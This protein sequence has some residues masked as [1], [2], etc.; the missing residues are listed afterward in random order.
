M[1]HKKNVNRKRVPMNGSLFRD[2]LYRILFLYRYTALWLF[3][4]AVYGNDSSL[5]KKNWLQNKNYERSKAQEIAMESTEILL[6]LKPE[7]DI[8]AFLRSRG[9]ELKKRLLSDPNMVVL[10]TPS[11]AK[12]REHMAN[13]MSD[14]TVK[15]VYYDVPS[16]NQRMDFTPND[17]FFN[18]GSPQGFPGQW[19]LI[20]NA[21]P[22]F[23]SNVRGAWQ[24]DVTGTGVTIGI[25]D[26]GIDTLHPDLTPNYVAA[27]S[28]DFVGNDP[29]PNPV[30]S[31]ANH[32]T[33]VAG[34]A[35]ARGGNGLGVTGAAPHAKIAGLRLPFGVPGG[36]ISDFVDAVKYHSFG[37]I[38]TIK[39]KNHSYGISVPFVNN[40][41]ER[42]AL[43]ESAAAGTIH[44]YAAGNER[45]EAGEDANKKATQNS[46]NVITVAALANTGRFATYSNFG[47]NVFVTAPSSSFR[48]GEFGVTTTDR[49]G[50]DGY[51]PGG[52]NN[53]YPDRDYTHDF[54]GT[55]SASPLVAGVMALGVQAN[56]NMNVRMAKHLLVRS[57]DVVDENDSTLRSDDGWKTNGAGFRFN[58]NY[59]F[60]L[61]DADEFTQLATQ[62]SGVTPLEAE[63]T[64]VLSVHGNIPDV[65]QITRTFT[66]NSTSPLEELEVRLDIGHSFRGDL[67]AFLT[68]PQGTR[69]RLF[70]RHGDDSGSTGIGWWFT[71]NA[72]WGENPAG[73]WSLTVEDAFE[74][75]VGTW[76]T[77]Q[78]RARMGDLV[79]VN[80]VS[81]PT[82]T[83]FNPPTGP[84]GTTVTVTGTKLSDASAVKFSSIDATEFTVNSPTQL[85]AIVPF[86]ATTG[87]I[88]VITPGGT[89]TT[90][91]NFDVTI[92]PVIREFS[93]IG[94]P[95]GTNITVFG[96]NFV[97]IS[98]VKFNNVDAVFSVNSPTQITAT[99]PENATT[100][101]ITIIGTGG[102]ATSNATFVISLDPVI[103][104][105]SPVSGVPG[106]RVVILGTNFTGVTAVTFNGVNAEFAVDSADQITTTA[107]NGAGTG[108]LSLRTDTTTVDSQGIFSIIAPPVIENFTP[109]I[110]PVASS[111]VII[112]RNFNDVSAVTFNNVASQDV[113]LNSFSQVTATVPA[114]AATGP[115]GVTT[116]AG[117][118]MSENAFV[119][120]A[121]SS[122]DNFANARILAGES[123]AVTDTNIAT[124][125]ETDEQNHA[126][127][128]GGKSIWYQWNAPISGIWNFNTL[129]SNFDTLLAIY[130]GASI[131]DLVLVVAND[132][133]TGGIDDVQ[134]RVTFEASQG[135]LY[136]IAIDGK[137]FDTNVPPN[138][139][140]AS[141]GNVALS[142]ERITAPPTISGFT[143]TSAAVGNNVDIS[144]AGFLGTTTVQF[145]TVDSNAVS[146]VSDNKIIASVPVNATSGPIQVI[147]PL[148]AATS[149]DTLQ[150][151]EASQNDKFSDAQTL[152][153]ASGTVS[154]SNIGASKEP[155]EPNHAGN[156]GGSSIWFR[157]TA[158][159]SGSWSFDTQNSSF[160]TL[161]AV[162]TG[163]AI[164]NL[165]LVAENDDADGL[166]NRASRSIFEVM[167]DTAYSIAVDGYV[168]L[169]GDVILNWSLTPE[170]PSINGFTPT[171]GPVGTV[172][173]INGANLGNIISVSFN[174]KVT[175]DLTIVS[176]SE[177]TVQVP[178]SATSGPIRISSP[179]A[180]VTSEH[181]F[182]V[183]DNSFNDNFVDAELLNGVAAF[184]IGNNSAASKEIGEPNHAGNI[185]GKSIWYSWT[186]PS[187]GSWAFD[188][189]GSGFDTI[190]AVYI[191]DHVGDLTLI[192]SND[193][194][195]SDFTDLTSQVILS[196]SPGITYH[197]AVDG[198]NG[199]SG[200]VVLR[201]FQPKISNSIFF[202]SFETDEGYDVFLPDGSTRQPL[203][204]QNAWLQ[205]GSRGN[206]LSS[207]RFLGF[208]QEAFVGGVVAELVPEPPVD[209]V[210]VWAPIDFTPN[211]ATNPV[212]TFSVVLEVA[213]S[214][215]F[216]YDIFGWEFY[217]QDADFLLGL[218]FNNQTLDISFSLD[219]ESV[220]QTGQSFANGVL[221]FLAIKMD[222]AQNRWSATLDDFFGTKTLVEDA[223]IS[224]TGDNALN[225]G[226]IDAFWVPLN[227]RN[228]GNNAMFFD[229]YSLIEE[230]DN[231]PEFQLQPESQIAIAGET[232][233]FGV[234]AIGGESLRYQWKKDGVNI[235]DATA[236]FLTI[237][238]V[239]EDNSGDYTVEVTSGDDAITSSTATL[240]VITLPIITAQPASQEVK[241]RD[242]AN[243]MVTALSV[244][245]LSYQWRKN[246]EF[247]TNETTDTLSIENVQFED[248][249]SYSAVLSNLAGSIASNTVVLTVIGLTRPLALTATPGD[250]QVSLSW[251]A[252]P[253][254][255]NPITDYIVEFK[256]TADSTFAE[257]NDGVSTST[258][259]SL[260]GLT[261]G[262]SYD[263]R[264][265]AVNSIGIGEAA[266]ITKI[267]GESETRN[268]KL[269]AGWNLISFILEP[270][271]P[272][273]ESTVFGNKRRGQIWYWDGSSYQVATQLISKTGYWV[274]ME[275][276]DEPAITG[277]LDLETEKMLNRS[278]WHLVGPISDRS[279]SNLTDVDYPNWY[280]ENG[281]FKVATEL[282]KWKGYWIF[283]ATPD[284]INLG[285]GSGA[286]NVDVSA[287]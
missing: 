199:D 80:T 254:D 212:L 146:V 88:S 186:A 12:A 173:T 123:G 13:L 70:I 48:Q 138:F 142:W 14:G 257:L 177:L 251:G 182:I 4:L 83:N 282:K 201:L 269:E 248:G 25:A 116:P 139:D 91:T 277:V 247:L 252:P 206:G 103:S 61:I 222:F 113:T 228:P 232:V 176:P 101:R 104:S 71:S 46:P 275:E 86:G 280:W 172:V 60:G 96:D 68:S 7:T 220:T 202:T 125:K 184:T 110:G 181:H 124:T 22:N 265:S 227:S 195:S 31:D 234:V 274:Y 152:L 272:P 17:P 281:Q 92:S 132:D 198:F 93:P 150:I 2:S 58:Q 205:T 74:R 221:Y 109:G 111:V 268:L 167:K 210:L 108:I 258:T 133:I 140:N 121:S 158:P 27:D 107:P 143:P 276:S 207:G 238:N 115:I 67:Q 98:A 45:T 162:Y 130:T 154:G 82:I 261:N 33:S 160:D 185:G 131:N 54:G 52:N 134:S 84:I 226:D 283:L 256:R 159:Q 193:D 99:V 19:H 287:P 32:G 106:T 242:T 245:D 241:V 224:A 253:D 156:F 56:P 40:T 235:P 77:Y 163:N 233:T 218:Y 243:F 43:G 230:P 262:I 30:E 59:G 168:G 250:S 279:S 216:A 236:T 208:G 20:Y 273:A 174:E 175:T 153:G 183:T 53:P 264:V 169:E 284:T 18:T 270:D 9:L 246:G 87:P 85:T 219:D 79:P 267:I 237:Q 136:Y 29:V 49:R 81:P 34:V 144:G 170:I 63:D 180:S 8:D 120:T 239:Q 51:N 145:N 15:A 135:M 191:G 231:Q 166:A 75:D 187:Q 119:V 114:R 204:G 141:A 26:D 211:T 78:V 244:S 149:N 188:T 23:D 1:K 223:A 95:T 36:T 105:F 171:N 285:N 190:L 11:T 100:G 213:D 97:N 217:N 151:I 24:R 255:G 200:N 249:G 215:N 90:T 89:V 66:L 196:A 38:R 197:I 16:L 28:F 39:V 126:D 271:A 179:T 44:V 165:T 117:T 129:G 127:N 225:I 72:Y 47:A 192:E 259:A 240:S 35:A 94:G 189:T 50:N 55:S 42:D 263:F 64:G 161:L 76:N 286:S 148:G 209:P 10:R 62:Y 69:S 155:G 102:T 3:A 214:T 5:N 41:A 122:N 178:E 65:G 37:S 57:C 21:Q 229:F 164:N 278:G 118:A 128:A 6:S 266:Q 112:G 157:W 260:T 73:Q 194:K 137:N 203:A 147:T